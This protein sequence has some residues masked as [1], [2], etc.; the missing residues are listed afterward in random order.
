MDGSLRGSSF[1]INR[2]GET[3][4][5]DN[6]GGGGGRDSKIDVLKKK[7]AHETLCAFDKIER[8]KS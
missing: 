1:L 5:A 3:N 8:T 6:T 2:F 4:K 7:L